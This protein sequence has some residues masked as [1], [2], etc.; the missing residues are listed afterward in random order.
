MPS[1]P[2]IPLNIDLPANQG[3][4]SLSYSGGLSAAWA[5]TADNCVFD[6]FGRLCARES[7]KK[8][9]T[10]A[11]LGNPSMDSLF[12]YVKDSA[13]THMIAVSGEPRTSTN[14]ILSTAY[15]IGDVVRAVASPDATLYLVCT[16]AGTSTTT[17]PTW[18]TAD[19]ATTADGTAT[20][21]TVWIGRITTGSATLTERNAAIHPTETHWKFQNFEGE[22]VG[23][24]QG[25]D[26][27]YWDGSATD[28]ATLHSKH[29]DWQATT[30]YVLGDTVKAVASPTTTYYLVCTT[31]GTS[32]SSEATW[33]ATEGA[34]TTDNSAVWTTV[35]MPKGREC[36]AA[37]GRVFAL[38]EDRTT[39]D[40]SSLAFPHKFDSTNGG[41]SIDTKLVFSRNDDWVTSIASFNNNL[42]IFSRFNTLIFS[43]INDPD[44]LVIVDQL[45]GTGCVAR[46]SVKNIGSDLVFLS[47]QGLRSLGRSITYEKVPLQ[48]LSLYVR[49]ELINEVKGKISTP[50]N[51]T[52]IKSEYSPELGLYVLK[53]GDLFYCFDFKESYDVK[54]GFTPPRATTWSDIGIQSMALARD[55]TLYLAKSGAVGT[56]SGYNEWGLEVGE[57]IDNKAYLMT[58]RSAWVDMAEIDPSLRSRAKFVKKYNAYFLGGT[59]YDVSFT[60]GY[61]FSNAV[62]RRNKVLSTSAGSEFGIAEYGVAEWSG[63]TSSRFSMVQHGGSGDTVQMGLDV[64]I[65]GAALCVSRIILYIKLGRLARGSST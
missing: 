24:A 2:L 63:N 41:G 54:E 46:D 51:D 32:H 48:E 13:T 26:P 57:F 16:T 61:D 29:S 23:F 10:T 15:V 40:Y 58:Y 18:N 44:N 65:Q 14:W 4:N 8:D 38:R 53:V 55:G 62:H 59:G 12:E 22:V 33:N 64:N 34:T 9:T 52:A 35:I 27:I 60:L 17:E 45:V 49:D 25:E 19:A 28:F 20:W 56:Y 3:I 1:Q 47:F 37:Y 5:Q 50:T 31:A 43:G 30:A 11:Y 39:I 42:V 36:L 21:T 6:A 7:F